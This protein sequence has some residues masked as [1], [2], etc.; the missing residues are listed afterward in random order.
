MES[1]IMKYLSIRKIKGRF[2]KRKNERG[3]TTTEYILSIGV[4]VIAVVSAAYLFVPTFKDGVNSLVNDISSRVSS[5]TDSR[6]SISNP[7]ALPTT[8][9]RSGSGS[10][11][12]YIFDPRTGRWHDPDNHYLMVTFAEARAAGCY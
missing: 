8:G 10:E 5:A 1:N 11:C 4:I 12:P 2:G 7:T 3:Q 9:S 6:G